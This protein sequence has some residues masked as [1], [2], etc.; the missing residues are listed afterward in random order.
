V[1]VSPAAASAAAPR[2]AA[3]HVADYRRYFLLGLVAMTAD[4][5][6]VVVVAARL[7]VREVRR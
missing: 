7:Y 2:L 5:T 6:E 4:N 3:L 1:T